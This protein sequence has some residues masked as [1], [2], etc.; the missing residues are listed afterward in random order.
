MKVCVI[1]TWV[2]PDNAEGG[3]RRVSEAQWKYLPQF[4][5]E[6][7]KTV[8]SADL[9]ATHGSSKV[10]TGGKPIVNHNHGLMWDLYDWPDW[11]HEINKQVVAAMSQAVAHTAPSRWVANALTRGMLVHPEVIHHGIDPDEWQPDETW[12]QYVLWNKARADYVSNPEDMQALARKLPHVAFKSTL[13]KKTKNVAIIGT[14]PLKNMKECIRHAGVYLCTARET[15]GIGTLEAMACGVPVVGWDW[16]GQAEII[17]HG[18]TGFLAK[19][20]DYKALAEGVQWAIANR[21]TIGSNARDDVLAV[22]TDCH[23]LDHAG[24]PPKGHQFGT[25]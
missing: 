16:G 4:G 14:M 23:R 3:I 6:P 24:M 15:F 11:A 18:E 10:D 5:V 25:S 2:K 21:D 1:P 17:R 13:G 9:I 20:Y 8:H 7:V 19:P 12:D 22:R